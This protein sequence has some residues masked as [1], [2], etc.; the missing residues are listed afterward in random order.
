MERPA[1]SISSPEERFIRCFAE[2]GLTAEAVLLFRAMVYHFYRRYGRDFPWR[3]TSDPYRILVSEIMLQQTQTGR[4]VPK[5]MEFVAKFPDFSSLASASV[6]QVLKIWK[7]LGYNRRALALLQAAQTVESSF[8]G[9]LPA[10]PAVLVTFPGIG[11]YTAAAV[12]AFAFNR[13]EVLIETNIRAVYLHYFFPGAEGVSDSR[14]LPFV[15]KTLDL[16]QPRMWYYALMD[17][18][19][20]LKE[21]ADPGRRSAGYRKQSPFKGSNRQLRSMIL[22]LLMEGEPLTAAEIIKGTGR[23]AG[24]VQRNLDGLEKEGFIIIDGERCK[25]ADV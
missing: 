25:I 7:G 14:I 9:V 10:S 17:Y 8:G 12:A 16:K 18:G 6:G 19:S 20:A 23:D 15:E 22:S 3:H 1:E 11:S 24:A 13:P 2:K 4:V 5:Y 21:E